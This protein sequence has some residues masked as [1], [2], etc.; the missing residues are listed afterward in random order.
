MSS[1]LDTLITDRTGGFYN[2]EDLNRVGKAM[3]YVAE[4]L[5]GYGYHTEIN[6]RTDWTET[7]LPTCRDMQAYLDDLRRIRH[8]W[9]ENTLPHLPDGM[10][11]FNSEEA[12]CIERFLEK[13]GVYLNN[14]VPAFFY[15]GC[16][17]SGT[18]ND[19]IRGVNL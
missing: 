9:Y 5:A 18:V 10:S 8:A 14:L 1:I 6:P 11:P 16:I 19:L 4:R 3:Q 15:S 2:T 12:N 7:D 17:G 13:M